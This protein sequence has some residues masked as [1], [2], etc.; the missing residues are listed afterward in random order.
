VAAEDPA[1]ARAWRAVLRVLELMQAGRIRRLP[2]RDAETWLLDGVPV[3]ARAVLEAEGIDLAPAAGP[4]TFPARVHLFWYM[5]EGY[6]W[7]LEDPSVRAHVFFQVATRGTDADIV[8]LLRALRPEELLEAFRRT[9][10]RLPTGV[11]RFWDEF[12]SRSADADPAGPPPDFRGPE[13]RS[14]GGPG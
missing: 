3:D 9:A 7:N 6:R 5:P 12:L 11:R 10:D 8:E 14:G 4:R 1:Y 13:G 2:F